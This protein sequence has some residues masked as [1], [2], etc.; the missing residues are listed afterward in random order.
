LSAGS[1]SLTTTPL[2]ITS[3]GTGG[4]ATPTLGG[5][6]YGT[7]TAYALTAS[8]TAGKVFF[9]TDATGLI[10]GQ[11]ATITFN[12]YPGTAAILST[13]EIVPAGAGP[14]TYTW[15]AT[16]GTADWTTPGSW[17]PARNTLDPGDVLLFPNGGNSTAINVP[18]ET[19]A[20]I[21]M[22]NSTR[23]TLQA[24]APGN[25]LTIAGGTGTDLDIP[26]GSWFTV[27]NGANQMS[28]V[29][30]NAGQ[31]VNVSGVLATANSNVNNIFN[32]TNTTTT[33]AST[34]AINNGGIV[35]NTTT[36]ELVIN[37]GYNH[38]H[39]I[40]GGTVPLA[41]WG[42]TSTISFLG[43]TTNT[44]APVNLD[45]TFQN[46]VYN[47]A[48]QTSLINLALNSNTATVNVNGN[49]TVTST[50]TGTI[51]FNNTSTYFLT[52]LGNYSQSAGNVEFTGAGAGNI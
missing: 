8:G 6:A 32:A 41:T 44:T 28:V 35:T 46:F 39:T 31:V 3:G 5:V 18:T 22:S 9:G 15:N 4:T 13:G 20:Q 33:V 48:S 30:S 17:T 26:S 7:G 23:I 51:R 36:A 52:I 34:G 27:G 50:G 21:T 49:F 16:S 24:G 29:F 43:Y 25:T 40:T 10:G 11:L 2:A 37:G 45:Q 1:L 12:G 19:V 14:S 42:A 47:C 38:L